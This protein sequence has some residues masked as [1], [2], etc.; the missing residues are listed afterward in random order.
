MS[1]RYILRYYIDPG[2]HEDDR[3]AELVNFCHKGKVEE[4]MLFASPEELYD[5]YTDEVERERWFE[6]AINAKQILTAADI[7]MS[8]NPW[9]TTA[10][11]SRGRKFGPK[12]SMI[13]P[14]VGENGVVSPVTA[15]P[16]DLEWQRQLAD[17][18]AAIAKRVAPTAIW[19]ED[20]WRLHNH[21]PEM[22]FGGCCC[23]LHMERFSR[24]VGRSVTREELLA[25]VLAPGKPHP[26]RQLWLDLWRDTMIEPARYL[27]QRV[28]EVNPDVRLALMSSVPD[29]HSIEGRDWSALAQ[30]FE[31]RRPLWLRP[32]L[33]PYTEQRPLTTVP[34]VTRQTIAYAPAGTVIYPE[35]ENS[36]RCGRYSK[37]ALY[38]AWECLH[39]ACYGSQGIT[40]NHYDMMGNGTALDEDFDQILAAIK[41]R[42]DAITELGLDDRNAVG[43]DVL[44]SPEQARHL[45]SSRNDSFFGLNKPSH[46]WSEVFYVLGISHRI[47]TQI[48]SDRVVAISG[49]TV[50]ALSDQEIRR[51]LSGRLILDAEAAEM[52]I[53]RGFGR[54]CGISQAGWQ[55]L[56]ASGYAYEEI[57]E[58]DPAIYGLSKPRMSAQRCSL[59]MWQIS[60]LPGAE[61]LTTICRFDRTPL[62]PGITMFE[63]ELGGKVITLAYPLG[64]GQFFVGFFN[65]FRRLLFHRV[66][67]RLNSTVALGEK[68]PLH[69]YCCRHDQGTF[70]ALINP[71]HDDLTTVQ[72]SL[73]GI[74]G[75][76]LRML[77]KDGQWQPITPELIG[78]NQYLLPYC[79]KSLDGLFINCSN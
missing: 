16:L 8:V 54:F 58:E 27:E 33:A 41:P 40:I 36:P 6:L 53:A 38:S 29:I 60:T 47:T 21:E 31:P 35:L 17:F 50:S 45:E 57:N 12:Q 77:D 32:H 10:H 4:V 65:N 72:F 5:G 18:F 56:N 46:I 24:M 75:N 42:L 34:A 15:C 61:L 52:L 20:D 69:V 30:A 26:W 25:N 44:T 63:N 74:S 48:D 62:S 43:I 49:K 14:Q 79:L 55:T 37:S 39:S 7:A 76:S 9:A 78:P 11:L 23:P 22:N 67:A 3:L 66:L 19:V 71:S 1:Y 13:Q 51:L 2:F 59:R 64:E 68:A 70:I 28:H 73:R